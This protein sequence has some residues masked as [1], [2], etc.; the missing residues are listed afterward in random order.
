M[1]PPTSLYFFPK[2]PAFNITWHENPNRKIKSYISPKGTL[3]A[4]D[5][6]NFSGKHEHLYAN[7]LRFYGAPAP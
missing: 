2:F 6:D 5:M 3:T 7:W 1:L 4:P